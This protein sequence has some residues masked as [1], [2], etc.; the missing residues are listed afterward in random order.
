MGWRSTPPALPFRRRGSDRVCLLPRQPHAMTETM[1]TTSRPAVPASPS[2]RP[3]ARPALLLDAGRRFAEHLPGDLLRQRHGRRRRDRR[4]RLLHPAT[5]STPAATRRR[6]RPARRRGRAVPRRG[7]P[8]GGRR[9]ARAAGRSPGRGG[10]QAAGQQRT[11]H[12]DRLEDLLRVVPPL[13]VLAGDVEPVCRLLLARPGDREGG[14]P[15][16]GRGCGGRRRTRPP[17]HSSRETRTAG[18]SRRAP[19]SNR[20]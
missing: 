16:R 9:T 12:T 17:A 5:C 2:K 4:H 13:R 1:P 7:R 15:E 20:H 6:P 3:R 18:L 14:R 11:G 19:S 10:E 8:P